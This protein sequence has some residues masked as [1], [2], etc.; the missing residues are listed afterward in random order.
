M[1]RPRRFKHFPLIH[2]D[3]KKCWGN[4]TLVG[5]RLAIF[6]I[7]EMVTAHE[8]DALI[9]SEPALTLG[10]INSVMEFVD[11]CLRLGL[12]ASTDA[13]RLTY[14]KDALYQSAKLEC[15]PRGKLCLYCLGFV[16]RGSHTWTEVRESQA[17]SEDVREGIAHGTCVQAIMLGEPAPEA[18]VL[19]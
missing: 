9:E 5:T 13:G 17:G 7:W 16:P 4:P 15:P 3:P 11:W 6:K 10:E 12:M 14:D 19:R 8:M 2:I 1:A 18:N